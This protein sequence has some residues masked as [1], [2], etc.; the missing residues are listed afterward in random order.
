VPLLTQT[1]FPYDFP[2][3]FSTRVLPKLS[4]LSTHSATDVA[5]TTR[6]VLVD[7]S[8]TVNFPH[9]ATSPL[10]IEKLFVQVDKEGSGDYVVRVGFVEEVDATNGSVTFFYTRNLRG[11]TTILENLDFSLDGKRQ[12]IS[13]ATSNMASISNEDVND[14]TNWRTGVTLACP[15][16]SSV[17]P[18]SGDIVLEVEEASGTGTVSFVITA[19]YNHAS[20]H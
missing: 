3:T 13:L 1:E 9:N 10:R 8:D 5:A 15:T 18:G 14:S 19:Q 7:L 6:Y 16:G 17:A 2:I 11:V 12:G 4:L 20:S